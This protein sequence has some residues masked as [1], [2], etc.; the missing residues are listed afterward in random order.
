MFTEDLTAFFQ[1]ADFASACTYKAGG[2][3]SG[4]TI[5][6]IFDNPDSTVF[7][8]HGTNPMILVQAADVTS[9]SNADTFTI[10]GVV[11]RGINAEPIDDG[12]VLRI[13][14]EKQ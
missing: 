12:A 9:F 13:Q 5:Q 1:N 6:A 11:Y 4:T 8:A 7:G 3:G 2:S 14:L 10:A